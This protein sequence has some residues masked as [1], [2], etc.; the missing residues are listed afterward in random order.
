MFK[1][2]D[3]DLTLEAELKLRVVTDEIDE[4]TD[5][6]ALQENLKASSSLLMHYQQIINRML[7]EQI[8]KDLEDFGLLLKNVEDS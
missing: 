2:G 1:P 5:I 4:C 3:F 6:K 7:L 8:N